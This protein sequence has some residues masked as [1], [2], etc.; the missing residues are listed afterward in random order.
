MAER[1]LSILN[2]QNKNVLG[3]SELLIWSL[4]FLKAA[5]KQG[6]FGGPSVCHHAAKYGWLSWGER[7]GNARNV[8]MKTKYKH[9]SVRKR[10]Y[11]SFTLTYKHGEACWPFPTSS[12]RRRKEPVFWKYSMLCSLSW[13]SHFATPYWWAASCDPQTT[14]FHEVGSRPQQGSAHLRGQGVMNCPSASW[15]VTPAPF[16][17]RQLCSQPGTTQTTSQALPWCLKTLILWGRM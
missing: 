10:N 12:F 8:G 11:L 5:L 6:L 14:L 2:I 17:C 3:K 9:S 13:S 16:A 1:S 7:G 15:E 4:T